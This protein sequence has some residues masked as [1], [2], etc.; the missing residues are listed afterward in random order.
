MIRN[1]IFWYSYIFLGSS[2]I[3]FFFGSTNL[4]YLSVDQA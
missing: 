1:N 3:L 4:F 2:D